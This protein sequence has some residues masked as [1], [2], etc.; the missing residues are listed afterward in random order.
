MLEQKIK[1]GQ[2]S[3]WEESAFSLCLSDYKITHNPSLLYFT[4]SQPLAEEKLLT[5]AFGLEYP[6]F[7]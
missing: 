4:S 6:N 1:A 3:G 5:S 7:L 2:L